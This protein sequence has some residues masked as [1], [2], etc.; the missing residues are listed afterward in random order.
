M[1]RLNLT[2]MTHKKKARMGVLTTYN[3]NVKKPPKH[4][5]SQRYCV[6]RKN[7]GI[8]KRKNKPHIP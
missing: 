3:K 7:A 1:W 4:K 8:T 5:G 2:A 6:L